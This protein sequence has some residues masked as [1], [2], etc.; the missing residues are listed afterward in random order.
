[1]IPQSTSGSSLAAPMIKSASPSHTARL[2]E[3]MGI[4]VTQRILRFHQ[5]GPTPTSDPS[6]ALQRQLAR[7]LYQRPG[8]GQSSTGATTNKT[9]V[10]PTS[11]Q[12][13]LDAPGL[14]DDF[15]L[16]LLSWSSTNLLAVALC[17]SSYIWNAESGSVDLLGTAAD[18]SYISS[19]DFTPD[20]TFLGVGCGNGAVEVWDMETSTRLRTMAGHQAQVASLGW[21]AHILS[22]GCA[23]GS[24]WHH[25][26]RIAN[27][28]V[29]ELLGHD[30]EV[31][32]LKWRA[33]GDFLASGAND[34]V[35]NVWDGRAGSSGEGWNGTP[36]FTKNNH[37]A[38][39]KVCNLVLLSTHHKLIM[40]SIGNSMVSV[41]KQPPGKWRRN[42]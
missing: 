10:I 31:C 22:S 25:D 30:G 24:I 32:G 36:V 1:M 35:L 7:P 3:N 29:M 33:D 4:N 17:E 34:N 20:G 15:Y 40:F 2:A 23:D 27:H 21:N 28:K 37:T 26:V 41:A 8:A 6:L 9:R 11:A 39:V 12:R 16:N 38:A 42:W 18:G 19:V 5:Q 13:V 14:I